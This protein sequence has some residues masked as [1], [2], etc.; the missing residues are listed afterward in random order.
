[1]FLCCDAGII[2]KYRF[3][4]PFL[5]FAFRVKENLTVTGEVILDMFLDKYLELLV[6]F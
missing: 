4:P 5:E 1:M 6:I 3:C 2:K